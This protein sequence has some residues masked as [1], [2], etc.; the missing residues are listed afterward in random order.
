MLLFPGD[1]E[2]TGGGEGAEE[3][4]QK[5]QLD[6][7][8][9]SPRAMKKVELDLDDAPFL[10]EEEAPPPEEEQQAPLPSEDAPPKAPPWYKRKIVIIAAAVGIVSGLAATGINQVY[11][12]L[13]SGSSETK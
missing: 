9:G 7:G 8:G 13:T 6:D 2:P 12:Q 10:E 5:A 4:G 1:D 3:L 11:K